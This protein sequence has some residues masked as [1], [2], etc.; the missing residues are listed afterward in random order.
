MSKLWNPAV[1]RAQLRDLET[2]L[3]LTRECFASHGMKEEAQPFFQKML[4]EITELDLEVLKR[5]PELS[6]RGPGVPPGAK[7]PC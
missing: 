5:A 2:E 1:L 7:P 6:R 4:R 3:R